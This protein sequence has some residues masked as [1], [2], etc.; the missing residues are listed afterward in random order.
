MQAVPAS[1]FNAFPGGDQ[2]F[3]R[4]EALVANGRFNFIC[5]LFATFLTYFRIPA[6]AQIRVVSGHG[7]QSVSE[8]TIRKSHCVI[9]V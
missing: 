3:H 4:L 1:F 9:D 7:Q 5:L 2:T 8:V 6:G